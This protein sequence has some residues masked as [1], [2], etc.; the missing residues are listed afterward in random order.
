MI[1]GFINRGP[2]EIQALIRAIGPSLAAQGVNGVLANPVL[3]VYDKDGALIATND[4]WGDSNQKAEIV[5][6]TIAPTNALES[7]VLLTLP[8]GQNAYTAIVRGANDSSGVGLIEAYFGDPYLTGCLGS[9][10][11]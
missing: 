8:V 6:T 3:E 4:D 9:S 10:C 1:G 7:A 5:A 2:R 11:P